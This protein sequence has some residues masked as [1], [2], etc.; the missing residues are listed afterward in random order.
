[1][2]EYFGAKWNFKVFFKSPLISVPRSPLTGSPA[3]FY[4]Y[5][6]LQDGSIDGSPVESAKEIRE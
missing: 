2:Y 3:E 6:M 5:S 1:M 4:L